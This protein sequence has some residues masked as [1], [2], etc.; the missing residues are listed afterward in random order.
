MRRLLPAVL[1]FLGLALTTC[2]LSGGDG[3]GTVLP[4]PGH[5]VIDKVRGEVIL[6]AVVQYPKGKPCIDEYGERIQA[7]AGCSKAAGADATMAGYFVFLT[8]VP[9]EQVHDAMMM[10]GCKPRVHYSI[11]E[12]KK[13]TGLRPDTK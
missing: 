4:N 9:A 10:L 12:G 2:R 7:F 1:L 11:Q 13:H 6:P 8:D 3:P 5:V